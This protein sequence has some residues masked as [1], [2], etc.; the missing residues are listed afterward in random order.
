MFCSKCGKPIPDTARFCP[1][2]GSICGGGTMENKMEGGYGNKGISGGEPVSSGGEGNVRPKGR[3]RLLGPVLAASFSLLAIAVLVLFGATRLVAN[4]RYTEQLSLGERYE[5]E[6]DYE[7]AMAAYEEAIRIDPKREDAYLALARLN[8]EMGEFDAVQDVLAEALER[9]GNSAEEEADRLL[10][11]AEERAEEAAQAEEAERAGADQI[12]EGDNGVAASEEQEAVSSGFPGEDAPFPEAGMEGETGHIG[13]YTFHLTSYDWDWSLEGYG[14]FFAVELEY[15]VFEGDTE[16]ERGLNA[17]YETWLNT[18]RL[19]YEEDEYSTPNQILSDID[20]GYVWEETSGSEDYQV[21]S[22]AMTNEVFSV[23]RSSYLYYPGAAHGM[24]FRETVYID[25]RTGETLEL[26]EFISISKEELDE[27]VR[28]A[29]REVAAQEP[30]EFSWSM[31]FLEE[32]SDF[33]DYSYLGEDGVIFYR[34][35]YELASYARGFVEITIP[36]EDLGMG[37]VVYLEIETP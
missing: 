6:L 15:P 1:F 8:L 9:A 12:E 3:R 13:P 11:E 28:D 24:P 16:A 30:E 36:Y 34:P 37:E 27:R 21:E 25:R 35:P 14:Q 19:E 10:R 5:Q 23:L 31:E 22:M 17:Y 4:R 33:A 18:K 7:A 26:E 20:E 29:F 2:C 32:I